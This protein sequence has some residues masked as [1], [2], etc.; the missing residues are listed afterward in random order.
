MK[1]AHSNK[2]KSGDEVAHSGRKLT[3]Q[4]LK[5]IQKAKVTENEVDI[6]DLD[7]AFAASDVVDT[8]TGE[9]LLE[10]NSENTADKRS[11]I[12]D[13]GRVQLHVSFP[14]RDDVGT[15]IRKTL[16]HD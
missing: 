16:R 7:G 2:S 6:S 5:E 9:V 1:L 13:S 12:L 15:V 10:A 11:K 3:G 14:E 4:I 8:T